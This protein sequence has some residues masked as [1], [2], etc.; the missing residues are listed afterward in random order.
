MDI[1]VIIFR[2]L[3]IFGAVAW[4]GA[5]W[6]VVFFI[7]PTVRATGPEG[8][9]FMAHL[10]TAR[11]YP[12]YIMAA[13]AIT[14]LAGIVLFGIQWGPVWNTPKGLTFLLG[15]LIGLVAGG[16][17]G[18]VGAAS[19]R[20]VQLGTEIAMQ[21]SPP[22]PEQGAQLRALQERMHSLGLGTATL[23]TLALLAMAVARYV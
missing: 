2:I 18:M 1:L 6:M 10:A 11:R 5:T 15:G 20:L 12:L 14:L 16:V 7:E 8:G 21:G 9:K 22:S 3:H 13:A 23:T 19:G 4:V 17:G